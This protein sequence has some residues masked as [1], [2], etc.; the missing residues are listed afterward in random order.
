MDINEFWTVVVV[1]A[2]IAVIASVVTAS[3]IR[4]VGLQPSSLDPKEKLGK[5]I[6]LTN[7]DFAAEDAGWRD[8]SCPEGLKVV[9]QAGY[10][11]QYLGGSW[12]CS[13]THGYPDKVSFLVDERAT[14]HTQVYCAP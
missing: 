11:C 3:V 13:A 4:N 12:G 5:D 8:C 2:I 9:G 1:S 6:V 7:C 14:A 10:N